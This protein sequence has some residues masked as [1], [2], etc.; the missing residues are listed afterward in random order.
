MVKLCIAPSRKSGPVEEAAGGNAELVRGAYALRFDSS[1]VEETSRSM[2]RF[3]NLL[4]ADV[5]FVAATGIWPSSQG[6]HT[7]SDLLLE[8]ARE[9]EECWFEADEVVELDA[10]RVLATGT[11]RARPSRKAEVYEIPFVNLW[12]IEHGQAVRIESFTDREQAQ[13]ALRPRLSA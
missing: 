8:A 1:R 12:T 7:V 6:R 4:S 10:R 2:G 13:A 9:W 11:V 5:E 3:L